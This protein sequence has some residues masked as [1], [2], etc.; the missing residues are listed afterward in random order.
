MR[1]P[2]KGPRTCCVFTTWR[3]R[4]MARAEGTGQARFPQPPAGFSALPQHPWGPKLR[5]W[6][7]RAR[8]NLRMSACLGMNMPPL[9]PSRFGRKSS[10]ISGSAGCEGHCERCMH[11]AFTPVP[12]TSTRSRKWPGH[13]SLQSP[14][15]RG[16][17]DWRNWKH[18]LLTQ[19]PRRPCTRKPNLLRGRSQRGSSE[20]GG[21]E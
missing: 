10:G 4:G 2:C 16:R 11:A 18:L 19:T 12:S 1:G 20:K 7:V 21:G 17:R 8:P 13:G 15:G 6:V 5:M 14:G 9:T 3:E